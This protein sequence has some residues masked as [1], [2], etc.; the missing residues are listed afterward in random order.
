M[1]GRR[2]LTLHSLRLRDERQP[3]GRRPAPAELGLVQAF[4]NT[5]WDLDR[6]RPERLRTPA[7]LA[8]WLWGRGLLARGVGLDE[9]DLRRAR[10]LREALRAL[11]LANNGQ[12]RDPVAVAPLCRVSRGATLRLDAEGHPE[13]AAPRRDLDGALGLLVAIVA[14]A[15]LDGRFERLKACPGPDCGWT[16]YDASRN[17]VS[18]WCSMSICGARVKARHYRARRSD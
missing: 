13:L 5:F 11:L 1:T 14:R 10:E 2:E 9:R 15:Q 17:R 3:A 18:T 7:Q 16:F 6:R 12:P 8:A 4:A